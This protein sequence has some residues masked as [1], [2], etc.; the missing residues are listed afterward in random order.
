MGH[1]FSYVVVVYKQTGNWGKKVTIFDLELGCN[2]PLEKGRKFP[3]FTCSIKKIVS[4]IRKYH[5][6]PVASWG[7]SCKHVFSIGMVN[8][9]SWSD[10]FVRSQLIWI[11]SI[12]KKVISPCSAG[13]GLSLAC[14]TCACR[15]CFKISNHR[16][17][18]FERKIVN[19]CLPISFNICFGC[20][21]ELFH[22]EGSFEYPQH[23]FW[24]RNKK[25]KFSLRTLN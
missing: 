19:I 17:T 24:L 1:C 14:V 23:V 15:K 25:F 4:M 6:K 16:Y 2:S 22:W 7:R 11:Y 8:S 10:G 20:S 21:K 18:I 3:V 9:G 12:F 5:N 13:Q